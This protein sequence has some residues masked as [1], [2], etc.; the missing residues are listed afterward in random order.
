MTISEC[1]GSSIVNRCESLNDTGHQLDEVLQR[2][3][4]SDTRGQDVPFG[5]EYNGH[6]RGKQVICRSCRAHHRAAEKTMDQ[7]ACSRPNRF[8]QVLSST[9]RRECVPS[10]EQSV[11]PGAE[12]ASSASMRAVISRSPTLVHSA[13]LVETYHPYS[14]GEGRL[15]SRWR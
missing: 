11:L 10:N 9:P 14:S 2:S 6:L 3:R 13:Y 12:R 15:E 4:P 8:H 5:L 1:R 7:H